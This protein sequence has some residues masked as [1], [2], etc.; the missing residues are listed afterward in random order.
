MTG[1][2]VIRRIW[3]S[4]DAAFAGEEDGFLRG[5]AADVEWIPL[6]AVLEGRVFQGHEGF[7]DWLKDLRRD[8]A[9]FDP[10]FEE[11]RD[12]GDGRHLVLG[13]W[14]A[15]GNS[16]VEL[17]QPASWLMQIQGREGGPAADVYQSE[18]SDRRCRAAAR[19]AG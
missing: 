5:I 10:V 15:R 14:R 4:W 6:M 16:G 13:Y 8:W 9:V 2:E 1:E 19:V 17:T 3:E 11:V 18:G 12:F 7:R